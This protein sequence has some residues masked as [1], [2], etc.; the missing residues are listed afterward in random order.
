LVEELLRLGRLEDLS[1][2]A[3]DLNLNPGELA[4]ILF[5][6]NV[7]EDLEA[8]TVG[9]KTW[10]KTMIDSLRKVAIEAESQGVTIGAFLEHL[11]RVLEDGVTPSPHPQRPSLVPGPP[12]AVCR[13]SRS[14]AHSSSFYRVPIPWGIIFSGP[15]GLGP[16]G[17]IGPPS[18]TGLLD[19][20]CVD[21]ALN[22][23]ISALERRSFPI[24]N[25]PCCYR[26]ASC[27]NELY[28]GVEP[29]QGLN[30]NSTNVIC[31]LLSE[32]A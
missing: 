14:E 31:N 4:W 1:H 25:L 24:V 29:T 12:R 10:I 11:K 17:T 5:G 7:R 3:G 13:F 30:V 20:N 2:L 23:L 26:I 18:H 21:R 6:G 32:R 22:F 8:D 27:Y 9:L 16:G 15:G 28:C 19:Y